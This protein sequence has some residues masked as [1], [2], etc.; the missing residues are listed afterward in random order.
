[1]IGPL[2]LLRCDG[3]QQPTQ[4]G[5]IVRQSADG[6]EARYCPSCD[7]VYRAWAALCFAKE[8]QLNR[9]L[10]LFIEE[11]RAHIPLDFVPQDLPKTE[12]PLAVL[13]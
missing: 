4:A 6:H 10:D 9:L 8:A 2:R 3:C 13:G 12:Q 1:M 5:S 7:E 11:T